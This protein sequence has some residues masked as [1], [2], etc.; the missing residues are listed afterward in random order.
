MRQRRFYYCEGKMRIPL[1]RNS[2]VP[3]YRQ[4]VNWL[5]DNIRSGSLPVNTR[6]PASRALSEE[7]GVSRITVMNA[8]AALESEGLIVSRLNSGVFVAPFAAA[9][10][11]ASDPK[12]MRWPLWQLEAAGEAELAAA[13]G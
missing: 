9:Q 2:A 13:P 10:R 12:K 5:K 6:L 11:Q 1:D 3:L 4:I 7:L 8:Y